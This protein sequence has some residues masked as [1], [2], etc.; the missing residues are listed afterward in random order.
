MKKRTRAKSF[1]ACALAVCTLAVVSIPAAAATVDDLEGNS[2]Y[3][4][5]SNVLTVKYNG[6][7]VSFP[8]AK[9][10][11]DNNG[12]TLIPVRFVAETMGA[13]VSWVTAN[14]TAVIEQDGITIK[15]PIGEDA[16]SVTKDG[17]TTSVKMDTAAVNRY[18]RTYVPIRFVAE[19]L[20]AW[21]GFSD[22]YATVQIYKD[23]LTP[24]EIDRL[25]G[26]YDMTVEEWFKSTNASAGL[27]TDA[28]FAKNYPMTTYCDGSRFGFENANEAKLRNPNGIDTLTVV[29]KQPTT[30]K[31]EVSG[32]IFTFGTQPDVEFSKLIL[33]EVKKGVES[34]YND[35]GEVS[36]TLRTDLSCVYWSRHSSEAS[37]YV[38]GVIS[39]AI[40]QNADMSYV[41]QYCDFLSNPVAGETYSVDVYIRVST[42]TDDVY[43]SEMTAL[44]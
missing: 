9:P 33:D 31:G 1:A 6:E 39:V 40:P 17:T 32:S 10:Y 25:H 29:G 8:D 24:E 12:R 19:S 15:V 4:L 21:V 7:S 38:R 16:I 13:D 14:D 35:R 2:G 34:Y 27:T 3:D 28:S 20:G 44:K 18:N 43:W 36:V 22:K 30:Y 42:F 37:T 5:T 41:A 26:Y 23:E 11:I